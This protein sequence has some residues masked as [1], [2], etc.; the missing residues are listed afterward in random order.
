MLFSFA[1]H[2]VVTESDG[3]SSTFSSPTANSA[4]EHDANQ[5]VLRK[6]LLDEAQLRVQVRSAELEIWQG[7]A[8]E[9]ACKVR[10]E[11]G[12]DW[13][14]PGKLTAAFE[15]ACLRYVQK[16]G[17]PFTPKSLREGLRQWEDKLRGHTRGR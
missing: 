6:Q 14:Q 3:K 8:Y 11:L 16:N 12:A 13:T 5:R 15:R 10:D 7:K 4:A 2:V 1:N 9:L 17:H